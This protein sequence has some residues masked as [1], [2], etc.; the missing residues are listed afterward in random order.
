MIG[1]EKEKNKMPNFSH[2]KENNIGEL[3]WVS[4]TKEYMNVHTNIILK[5]GRSYGV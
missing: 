4:A 2:P 3:H 5:I 1:C